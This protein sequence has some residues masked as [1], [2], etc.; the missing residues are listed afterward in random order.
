[1]DKDNEIEGVVE[2]VTAANYKICC[3]PG[4]KSGDKGSIYQKKKDEVYL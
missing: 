2:K 1:M 3:R 4:K